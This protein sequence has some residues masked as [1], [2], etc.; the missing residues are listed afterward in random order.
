ML[1]NLDL[2]NIHTGPMPGPKE[3][4]DLTEKEVAKVVCA[5]I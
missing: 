1:M 4:K 5:P 3:E 2:K